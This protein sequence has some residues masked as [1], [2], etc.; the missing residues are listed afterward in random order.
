MCRKKIYRKKNDV[1]QSTCVAVT[2]EILCPTVDHRNTLLPSDRGASSVVKGCEAKRQLVSI[3]VLVGVILLGVL[4][5]RG[6]TPAVSAGVVLHPAVHEGEHAG[7]LVGVAVA[8][9]SPGNVVPVAV[10]GQSAPAAK[11]IM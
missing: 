6:G 4:I 1:C 7:V 3:A 5:G 8:A 11:K 2:I 10:C 9:V